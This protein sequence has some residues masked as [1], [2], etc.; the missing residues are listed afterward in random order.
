MEKN[1]EL[2]FNALLKYLKKTKKK[3]CKKFAGMKKVR[4][5]ASAIEKQR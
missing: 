3:S 2:I 1:R 5:F 4:T